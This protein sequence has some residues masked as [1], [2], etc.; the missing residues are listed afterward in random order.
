MKYV[1]PVFFCGCTR[2]LLTQT[3]LHLMLLSMFYLMILY[4]DLTVFV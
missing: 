4:I 2:F 3:R 1:L